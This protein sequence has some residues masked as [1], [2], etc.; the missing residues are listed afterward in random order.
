MATTRYLGRI[1][2]PAIGVRIPEIFLE[3]ILNAC[4]KRN[5]ATGLMLSFGRETAPQAVIDAPPGQY[6][7]TLGHTGT[8]IRQYQTMC[9]EAAADKGVVVEIEADHLIIIGSATRAVQ[10]I[11]GVHLDT[12]ISEAELE[13]S[14]AYNRMAIEEAVSTGRVNF[15][16]TD[17]SDLFR[18][19]VDH[20]GEADLTA[21]F[22]KAFPAA[23][24]AALMDRYLGQT[25]SFATVDGVPFEISFDRQDVMRLATKYERSIT[26]NARL[27]REIADL[28][29]RPFGFEISLDETPEETQEKDFLWY[30]LEWKRRGLPC[31]YVAPNIGFHKRADYEGDREALRRKVARLH[32]M[33]LGVSGTLLS[34]HS[35]SGST[36]YSGKGPGTYEALLA[37]TGSRLKYKISGVYYELLMEL[38]ASQ[39]AGT[40]PRQL[41]ETIF[42]DVRDYVREV[43]RQNL[44]LA[45]DLLRQQMEQ[46]EREVAAGRDPFDPRHDFFRFYSYLALALRDDQNRRKHRIALVELMEKDR[47]FAQRFHEECE[48]LT[49]RLI[50]GLHFENNLEEG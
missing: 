7:I 20:L 46:Y 33:A 36:P 43:L 48:A 29:G 41:Y 14:L 11:A 17:T 3:G 22:E 4:V 5:T 12:H 18:P 28:L 13:K 21:L 23:E 44:P 47:E 49:L 38:M 40:H 1:H 27:Y 2:H 10:R 39:P 15:F 50:D 24:R 8:S 42:T 30:L 34:F 19:G 37:A 6:E 25:F 9:A 32:A 35:G 16:T 31:D 26:I 45:S